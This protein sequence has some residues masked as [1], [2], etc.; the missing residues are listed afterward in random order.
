MAGDYVICGNDL[1]DF[2]VDTMTLNKVELP[3]GMRH[4][5]YVAAK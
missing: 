3:I 5:M 2:M 4:Y 1:F